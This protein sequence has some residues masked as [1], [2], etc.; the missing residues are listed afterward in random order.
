MVVNIF[1]VNH[2][3]RPKSKRENADDIE[4]NYYLV[5]FL[6]QRFNREYFVRQI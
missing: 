5:L 1:H 3:E 6:W 4:I 2:T